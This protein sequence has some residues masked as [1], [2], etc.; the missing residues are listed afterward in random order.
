MQYFIVLFVCAIFGFIIGKKAVNRT[1]VKWALKSGIEQKQ[2]ETLYFLLNN[3]NK[4][5]RQ[6]RKEASKRLKEALVK[7]QLENTEKGGK[8]NG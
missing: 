7:E 6:A 4:L 8:A 1:V 5:E 3:G 2:A